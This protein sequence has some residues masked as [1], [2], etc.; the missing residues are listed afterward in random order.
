MAYLSAPRMFIMVGLTLEKRLDGR[1]DL[2]R[3]QNRMSMR[4]RWKHS[5]CVFRSGT[6]VDVET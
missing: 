3:L 4:M 6:V 5:Y 1:T 2:V